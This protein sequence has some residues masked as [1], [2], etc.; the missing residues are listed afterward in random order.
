RCTSVTVGPD[1]ATPPYLT[2]RQWQVFLSHSS[3]FWWP[4]DSEEHLTLDFTVLDSVPKPWHRTHIYMRTCSLLSRLLRLL[5][6]TQEPMSSEPK[7]G[8][9]PASSA[10]GQGFVAVFRPLG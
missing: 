8:R 2:V 7:S 1:G 3:G 10:Q 4:I 6:P 5:K 9:T